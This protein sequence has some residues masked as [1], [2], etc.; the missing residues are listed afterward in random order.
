MTP[1]D[2]R[3]IDA[4]K[5]ALNM[6]IATHE[7]A[8]G[9]PSDI[10]DTAQKF[11]DFIAGPILAADLPQ[12]VAFP[13]PSGLPADTIDSVMVADVSLP[14]LQGMRRR[15]LFELDVVSNAIKAHGAVPC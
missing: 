5:Q 7:G 6:A 13:L 15:M 8:G 11:M 2:Q 1:L 3:S 12:V 10:I 4:R 9:S 14:E